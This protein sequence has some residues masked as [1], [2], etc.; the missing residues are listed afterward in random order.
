[1][2]GDHEELKVG[3]KAPDFTLQSTDGAFSLYDRLRHGPVVLYF[4]PKDFTSG[5]TAE[6]CEFRDS[7]RSFMEVGA[8][9][10]GISGDSGE[11]HREF[12]G[13]YGLPFD[14]LSD[15]EGTVRRLFGVRQTLGVLPGRVTFVIDEK[16]I[17]VMKFSSQAHPRRH[18]REAL[19]A[20]ARVN[21]T[22]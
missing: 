2:P 21:R 14:L 5:C 8:T 20:L 11:R 16:G 6:A 22:G 7:I 12:A 18:V 15:A 10:A 13:K 19:E 17:I 9:V 1:M 4:Y 3:D